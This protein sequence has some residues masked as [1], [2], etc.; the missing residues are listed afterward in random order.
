MGGLII[1]CALALLL[2]FVIAERLLHCLVLSRLSFG[3]VPRLSYGG[4]LRHCE[5]MGGPIVLMV[6]FFALGL[7]YLLGF[8]KIDAILFALFSAVLLL[9]S[10]HLQLRPRWYDR[11]LIGLITILFLSGFVGWLLA[12]LIA[13]FHLILSVVRGT[14]QVPGIPAA[15]LAPFFSG[16]GALLIIMHDDWLGLLGLVMAG[17]LWAL[18][19]GHRFPPRWILGPS[20]CVCLAALAVLLNLRLLVFGDVWALLLLNLF[21]VADGLYRLIQSMLRLS[22][23][24]HEGPFEQARLRGEPERGLTRAVL[25]LSIAH[26]FVLISFYDQSLIV[27]SLVLGGLF[28]LVMQFRLF[29][30]RGPRPRP[31]RPPWLETGAPS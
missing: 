18:H 23:S 3:S 11:A 10:Q 1:L 29:L 25:A 5:I 21:V 19:Q 6:I 31:T 22:S 7:F 28:L 30:V 27:K 14:D 4:V 17:A 16:S 26:V 15:L 13:F 2:G 9:V 20:G 8:A 12:A 24:G